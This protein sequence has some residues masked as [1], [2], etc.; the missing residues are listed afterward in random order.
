M[1]NTTICII[2]IKGGES[3]ENK[4]AKK[5]SLKDNLLK[6]RENIS[7]NIKNHILFTLSDGT[8][9]NKEDEG[10]FILEDI[11]D[12]KVIHMKNVETKKKS[13]Y[14]LFI[15]GVYGNYKLNALQ[16]KLEKLNNIRNLIYDIITEEGNFLTKDGID[17]SKND[18]N[19]FILEEI[20]DGNRINIRVPEEINETNNSTPNE[21]KENNKTTN[22]YNEIY[23]KPINE[24]KNTNNQIPNQN[25][26]KNTLTFNLI[27]KKITF[28][29]KQS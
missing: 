29:K 24:F 12:G 15:N 6:I 8:I 17:I 26:E 3:G 27:E 23:T 13:K 25:N 2:E 18:E 16:V 20:L 14:E 10:N 19:N 7:N 5:L 1:S 11:I 28:K 21:F 4:F 22:Q 9:I